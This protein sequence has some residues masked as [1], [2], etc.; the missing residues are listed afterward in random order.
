M[1]S[2]LRPVQT[3]TVARLGGS[4]SQEVGREIVMEKLKEIAEDARILLGLAALWISQ[5]WASRKDR[6]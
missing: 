1:V 4:T 6:D 3:A 2:I 5:K